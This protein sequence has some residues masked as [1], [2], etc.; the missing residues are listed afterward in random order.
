MAGAG[1]AVVV[2]LALVSAVAP[3]IRDAITMAVKPAPEGTRGDRIGDPHTPRRTSIRLPATKDDE[4]RPLRL[5][6][7][8]L[9]QAWRDRELSV[10]LPDGQ[11]YSVALENERLEPGG[12]WTVVGRVRTRVGAQAMV[13]TFGPDAVFGVLPRPDGSLLHVTTSHG[14]TVVAPAGGLLPPGSKGTLATD[15]DYVVPRK[16]AAGA[17][18]A[19]VAASQPDAG[20]AKASSAVEVVVLALYT[21]DLVELRGSVSAAETEVTNL[22]AIANQS[23][24]DSGTRVRL[25]LAGRRQV[26]IDPTLS[27]HSALYAITYNEV[28]G[29]DLPQLR[30]EM[31]ADLVALVRPHLETHGTCGVAWLNGGGRSPQGIADY[32]GLSVSNVAPCGPHVLAHELG[33]N[34]GSAHDRETQSINGHLEYGAYQYSFGY[35]QDGPPA[36]ATVMAYTAGQPWVGYFSNPGSSVC[37]AK[38][39]VADRADNVRSLDAV[40]PIVA[41]FRGPPGTLSIV[42]AQ[43]VEPEPGSS[44]L[45]V[46]RVRLSGPAPVGGVGFQVVVTGGSAQEGVDYLAPPIIGHGI[47]EGARETVVVVEVV[48][49]A[50]NEP[51][52]TIQLSLANVTGVVPHDRTA[53]GRIVNDDPRLTMSGRMRFDEDVPAP[54]V[55]FWM[56]VSGL[57]GEYDSTP[58]QLSPPDFA[59]ELRFVKGA[60][61]HF[62]IDAPPPFA[63]LPF[64]LDEL[65]SSLVRDIALRKGFHVSGQVKLPAGQPA[66]VDP[67]YLDIRASIDGVYQSLPYG[68]LEPPDFRY[69]HWVVPGAW[70]YM[71]VAPPAPYQRFFA[72]HNDVR[73]DIVQDIELSTL[74]ALV[75][76]GGGRVAE[77]S[78]GPTGSM[79][80][81][82]ELSAPAPPGGVRFKYRTVDGTATAGSDYT[83]RQGTLEI[84]EGSKV[85]Y[86][87]SIDWSGDGVL[88]GNEYFDVVVSDVS[89]ANPVV[90][91]QRVTL[92]EPERKM[93]V[94][95]P[96]VRR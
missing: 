77:G 38:C 37:G 19:P 90:T 87:D 25:K 93:S 34:M 54:A 85:A 17:R 1:L 45:M 89:G 8:M 56:Y 39:G 81:V 29:V 55:P 3:G 67:L 16:A 14:S 21:D 42:D 82:I 94:P 4:P 70:L 23:F 73:S 10:A 88:E 75:I 24:I 79:S 31:A 74:P 63:I 66:L 96:S 68:P 15:P 92:T 80:L 44:S 91:R 71:E 26:G 52:E 32:F 59:Y 33:H 35:R 64:T 20:R 22:F 12:Q 95:L 9:E 40:A 28:P 58:V 86:T 49:D 78:P 83:A 60:S 5:T 30:D 50:A 72:V 36:F 69:S 53:T 65:E 7:G 47:P 61:P 43:L 76:W 18:P 62:A 48:G 46:F 41:G 27:N 11:R 6:R 84:P 51:D 2:L 13:L 57:S